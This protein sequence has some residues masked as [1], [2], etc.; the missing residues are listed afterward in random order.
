MVSEPQL[1][2]Y[3]TVHLWFSGCQAYRQAKTSYK[4]L[5][6][7]ESRRALS[8]RCTRL[9]VKPPMWTMQGANGSCITL[10]NS[11][12]STYKE[13]WVRCYDKEDLSKKLPDDG[14]S[15][16]PEDDLGTGK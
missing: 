9:S 8:E 2:N 16:V 12:K 11:N 15:V 5:C 6:F 14:K 7:F 3:L 13:F 1:C 4:K 10:V